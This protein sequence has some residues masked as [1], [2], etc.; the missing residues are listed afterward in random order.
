MR[1]LVIGI[2][3]L[4]VINTVA[5][6]P[7]EDNEIR[8]LSQRIARGGNGTNTLV[9]LSQL[10]CQCSWAGTIADDPGSK[11]IFEELERYNI[12]TSACHCHIG[13]K[14]PTSYVTVSRSG[15]SR[16]IVHY[17]DLPEYKSSDFA[18]IDSQQFDWIHFEGRNVTETH[19]MLRQ[20]RR[21]GHSPPVSLEVEKPREGLAQLLP[22][23]DVLLFSRAYARSNGYRS[24]H[25]LFEAIR[26][27]NG[28]ALCV[29]GWGNEGAWLQ[30]ASGE[31][32]HEPAVLPV[33]VVDTL[34]AGDV[35]N[36]GVIHGLL[37]G[38]TPAEV[39]ALA[40]RLAGAKCGQIGFDQLVS[41]HGRD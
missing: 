22:F 26:P 6:Y 35:L 19:Q 21:S 25:E 9:V 36:A 3:T 38:G 39:L 31:T 13:G 32:L 11:A 29:C 15:G 27:L 24:P 20:L 40:V 28:H 23:V 16:T 8:A 7:Q 18:A 10:G 17:R 34:G 12:D 37:H 33:R 41:A 5:A 4:D 30:T 14:A 2:A 1:V